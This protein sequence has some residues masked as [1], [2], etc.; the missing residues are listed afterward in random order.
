M[1]T[2]KGGW[3][4]QTFALATSNDSGGRKSRIRRSKEERKT[5]VESFINKYQKS[6]NG[7]FPSLNLT[8]KEVGGSFYT[9]RE[10]VREIIQENRVLGPAKL[11]SEEDNSGFPEQHP[12]GSISFDPKNGL[13]LSDKAQAVTHTA[14]DHD[15]ITSGEHIFNFSPQFHGPEPVVLDNKQIVNRPSD[16]DE[17]DGGSDE[18]SM[19]HFTPIHHQDSCT[20][21][22]SYF[23]EHFPQSNSQKCVDDQI[24]NGSETFEKDQECDKSTIKDTMPIHQDTTCETSVL[25]S[26]M[27][28]QPESQ[29]LSDEQIFDKSS[30]INQQTKVVTHTEAVAKEIL[31][32]EKDIVKELETS[33]AVIAHKKP[34][35]LVETFPLRAVSKTIHDMAGEDRKLSDVTGTLEEKATLHEGMMFTKSSSTLTNGKFEEK[36]PSLVSSDISTTIEA[37]TLD[38]SIVRDVE[39]KDLLPDGTKACDSPQQSILKE[40]TAVGRKPYVQDN[41]SFQKESNPILDRINLETWEGTSKKSPD[42]NPL[43]TLLK[44]FISAFMKFWTE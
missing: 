25:S 31:D 22:V 18:L 17:K 37:T 9:V 5:M 43:L 32:R 29:R 14:S 19:R 41:G 38:G 33:E 15:Q 23:T 12:V 6:N 8:H 16:A 39:A 28:P 27:F 3:V 35:V 13:P 10:I 44:G 40:P 11:F 36:L 2:I 4:G 30:Q 24:V 34:E 1:Y 20:D 42:P 26:G 21:N 7:N